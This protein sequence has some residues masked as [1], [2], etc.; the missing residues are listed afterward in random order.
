MKSYEK[1]EYKELI[2]KA[3]VAIQNKNLDDFK[4][5]L[6]SL[7]KIN[8]F[9]DINFWMFNDEHETWLSIALKTFSEEIACY[10][11][12]MFKKYQ[13]TY[14]YRK[15][16]ETD[17][18]LKTCDTVLY[19]DS[20]KY[21]TSLNYKKAINLMMNIDLNIDSNTVEDY[22]YQAIANIEGRI[23]TDIFNSDVYVPLW[24]NHEHVFKSI[25][26]SIKIF[27]NI[28]V[29]YNPLLDNETRKEIN[30]YFYKNVH[31]L[32]YTK[33][34]IG[35]LYSDEFRKIR[36]WC[37]DYRDTDLIVAE[38]S[39]SNLDKITKLILD[40]YNENKFFIRETLVNKSAEDK[41]IEELENEVK[42]L[43]ENNTRCDKIKTSAD[44]IARLL[45][46]AQNKMMSV[47]ANEIRKLRTKVD[48]LE[49]QA[50]KDKATIK[51]QEKIAILRKGI[52]DSQC[53]SKREECKKSTIKELEKHPD[54]KRFRRIFNM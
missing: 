36:N 22:L 25:Y 8:G 2:R 12:E 24:V 27:H 4:Y 40:Q 23:F 28:Y 46:E 15:P 51:I 9:G 37:D 11:I 17:I 34:N 53:E 5:C 45:A 33:T 43:K 38:T 31:Q 6:E 26:D 44:N 35:E 14:I 41:R 1:R 19:Q 7:I 21:M 42:D 18:I 16:S 10:I 30:E 20:I 47:Q 49:K 29:N 39:L 54:I 32:F 52:H 13:K 3:T 50:I 48:E